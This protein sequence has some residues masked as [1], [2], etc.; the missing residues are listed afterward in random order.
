MASLPRILLVDDDPALRDTLAELLAHRGY[1]VACAGDGREALAEL[2]AHPAPCLILL[3][4]SMPVMDGRTF[5]EVKRR[6]PRLAP[7]PTIV[8]S[9]SL[10]RG[11][12]DLAAAAALA[13]PFD[14]DRLI[15]TIRRVCLAC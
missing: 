5:L 8:L 2:D 14:L 15:A 10:G 13:K 4:L 1:E 9:A 12:D 6:D 7:I 11:V 3:D